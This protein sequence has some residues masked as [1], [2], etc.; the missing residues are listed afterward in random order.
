MMEAVEPNP[1]TP[2]EYALW[3]ILRG[4]H[5]M[6]EPIPSA[7][8]LRVMLDRL[9][10]YHAYRLLI[11]LKEKSLVDCTFMHYHEPIRLLWNPDLTTG[12][13]DDG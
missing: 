10:G 3:I 8:Q 1:M 4:F 12:D 9:S 2:D 7:Y 6:G 5:S 13:D 11:G